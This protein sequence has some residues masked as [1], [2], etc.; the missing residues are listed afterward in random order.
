MAGKTPE[1]CNEAVINDDGELL[2]VDDEHPMYPKPGVG[3][4]VAAGLSSVGI[5][6][7]TVSRLTGKPCRCK[8]RR[9]AMNRAGRH[10]GIGG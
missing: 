2:Q 9:E 1:Q 6:P 10:F 4:F 5:T 3:D 8:E 7:E